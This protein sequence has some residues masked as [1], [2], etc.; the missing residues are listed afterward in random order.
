VPRGFG[1]KPHGTAGLWHAAT[2]A[3][4]QLIYE[5]VVPPELGLAELEPLDPVPPM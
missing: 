5:P 1:G 4:C 2:A 3:A